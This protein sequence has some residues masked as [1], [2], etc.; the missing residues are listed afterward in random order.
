MAIVIP[1][2][3]T[4]SGQPGRDGRADTA[5]AEDSDSDPADVPR[6]REGALGGPTAR[7]HVPVGG[8]EPAQRHQDQ[9]QRGIGDGVGQHVWGVAH[10]DAEAASRL[11]IDG[12]HPGAV[13][14]DHL[15]IGQRGHG[16]GIQA[17]GTGSQRDANAGAMLGQIR[18]PVFSA[19]QPHDFIPCGQLRFEGS[20]EVTD[21]Q[22]V[23]QLPY[24]HGSIM[25]QR[26]APATG[27]AT[28]PA[29]S[30]LSV[31][32][33]SAFGYHPCGAYWLVCR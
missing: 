26:S 7:P 27:S 3:A 16:V 22:D 23:T 19:G 24:R 32:V 11:Q 33:F 4:E 14:D 18:G 10:A 8:T 15:E 17:R 1:D 31:T 29:N 5:Q 12:I 6:V 2:G 25:T 28:G 20:L 21:T 9:A 30:V 13:V